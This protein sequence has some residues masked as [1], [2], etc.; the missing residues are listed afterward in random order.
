MRHSVV[1]GPS[2]RQIHLILLEVYNLLAKIE[3]GVY[4][5]REARVSLES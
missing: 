3:Y 4:C 5:K 2:E 1:V